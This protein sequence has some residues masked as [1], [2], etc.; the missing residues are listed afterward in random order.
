[1]NDV[2]LSQSP[3]HSPLYHH[4]MN[5]VAY[6]VWMQTND[7]GQHNGLLLNDIDAT[8][9]VEDRHDCNDI[10]LGDTLIPATLIIFATLT[11]SVPVNIIP[12]VWYQWWA[13]R[14]DDSRT[15]RY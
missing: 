2:R 7:I 14:E 9:L 13:R 15:A 6:G 5:S 4:D 3:I 10:I 11:P 12:Y 1:M 8:K